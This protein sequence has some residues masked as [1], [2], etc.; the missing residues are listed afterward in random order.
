MQLQLKIFELSK[1]EDT[2]SVFALQK[3]LVNHENAKL[4]ATRKITQDNLGKRTAG[5]DGIS[6]LSPVQ[7]IKLLK[8]IRIGNQTDQIRRVTILKPNGKERHLGIPTIRDRIKQCLLKFALEPQY[9]AVFEPNSFGFRPGRSA[10]DA[11]K[12]IVKCLQR[13]PKFILDADIKGYFDQISHFELLK[14]IVTFPLFKDQIEVW[15][16]AGIMKDF[17]GQKTSHFPESG[18]PQG[19]VI[20]PLLSNI[21]L[22]GMEELV[23]KRGVYFVR[24]ADDF[25]IL[26]SKEENLL[27]AKQKTELFLSKLNLELSKEKTKIVH[28]GLMYKNNKPGVDF[29]GFNFVN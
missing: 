6:K 25:L 19:G 18:T 28:S 1:K 16:K 3:R 27:E 23:S 9:E 17:H 12:T 5:V 15:L 2:S 7:R 26:S 10:N 21:A 22:H 29:L 8:N 20:S 24:Y 14:K 13:T 4:L 11:R